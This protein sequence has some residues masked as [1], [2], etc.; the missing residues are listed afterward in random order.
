M[1]VNNKKILIF[2]SSG[3]LGQ[4]LVSLL[5]KD[6]EIIQFDINSPEES[7]GDSNFV[8]GSILDTEL[9]LT[10]TKDVDIVYHFAAMTDLDIVNNNPAKAIEVNI[11]GTSN[12]LDACIKEKVE[13]F[14]FSSSVYV[15]SQFGGVYK[16]TK[17]ACELLI[18][19]FD[20]MHGLNYT[21]LQL[22]SV[23]GPAAKQTNLI[24]R[25]IKEALTTDQFQ[26]SGSGVEERQYIFVKDVVNA[27]INVANRQYKNKKVILLGSESVRISQLMEMI[28]SQFEKDIYKIFKKDGYGIHYKSS[29]FQT[30]PKGAIYYKLESPTPLK[31]GLRETIKFIQEELSNQS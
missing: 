9:V 2:G 18:E 21:I 11:A 3:F 31:D 10:A 13:R 28:S 7:I 14:I 23:Y 26:H 4:H 29:P 1:S 22:G 24:S 30:D 25:L 27:L 5:K 19:D 16:S 15:Y 20:K 8:Q 12:I 6:N 17:Q